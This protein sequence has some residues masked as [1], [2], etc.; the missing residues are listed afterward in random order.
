MGDVWMPVKHAAIAV[1]FI[2]AAVAASAQAGQPVNLGVDK[3]L[4]ELTTHTRVSGAMPPQLQQQ[5]QS[6][7]PAQRARVQAAMQAAMAAAQ[8]EHVLKEC[9]TARRLS[10]AF[11]S[12]GHP[13]QCKSTLVSN[14]STDFEYHRVCALQDGKGH[15]ETARFHLLDPHHLSG[16]VDV[17]TT[18][19]G[20]S[21]T[22]HESIDGK[23]LAASCGA[24]KD[25][26][27]VK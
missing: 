9:M 5:L 22:V 18:G 25:G 23:W 2:A 12:A 21:I 7:P 20:H 19:S 8:R 13:A 14:T 16:T 27:I 24:V 10:N 17:V 3:G 1:A 26:T 6:M 15:T 4:W 11:D